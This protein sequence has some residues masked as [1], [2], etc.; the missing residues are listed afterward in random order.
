MSTTRRVIGAL[1]FG[2]ILALNAQATGDSLRYLLP[3]DTI[4][5]TIGESEEKFF[6]HRMERK[7]TLYSLA[8][9]YGLSVEELYYFNPGLKEKTIAPGQIVK[10]SIPNRAIKRYKDKG[11]QNAKHVSVYYKVKKGDTMFRVCKLY[12]RMPMEEVMERNKLTSTTLKDGQLIHVG[13][14]SIEGIPPESRQYA[15]SDPNSRSNEAMYRVYNREGKDKKQIEHQGVAYWQ[16][17]SR[18]DSDLYA[19]HRSATINSVI[20]V[21]NPM[22]KRTVYVKVIGRIPDTVYG[23][24][25]VVVL[26][27]IAAKLLNAKDP[28]FFVKVKYI[29]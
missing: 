28:R 20:S 16:K 4:L 1:V 27:P 14:M 29:Q 9:F 25:V 21:N 11:F 8:R 5:L 22:S 6:E 26:S 24:D 12:F 19:L 23:D 13:W 17:N 3:K 18:E 15:N 7:Q 10:V 2:C